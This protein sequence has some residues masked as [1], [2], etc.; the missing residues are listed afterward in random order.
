MIVYTKNAA[1]RFAQRGNLLVNGPEFKLT[2]TQGKHWEM[3]IIVG[4]RKIRYH[5]QGK[6]S[7]RKGAKAQSYTAI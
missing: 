6:I 3:L 7:S 2:E 5:R 1:F 4:S